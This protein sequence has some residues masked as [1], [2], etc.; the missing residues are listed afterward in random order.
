[1]QIG[2][3]GQQVGSVAQCDSSDHAADHSERSDACAATP[4]GD[5][6]RAGTVRDRV[7]RQLVE[8]EQQTP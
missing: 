8:P 7:E 5:V 3:E 6:R 2:V 1:V 4:A